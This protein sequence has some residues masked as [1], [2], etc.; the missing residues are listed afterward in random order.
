M[1]RRKGESGIRAE[2]GF[3]KLGDA[4]RVARLKMLASALEEDPSASF[5]EAVEDGAAL[6]GTY[7]LLSNEAG[8]AE[9]ILAGDYRQTV[10]RAVE[11]GVVLG[12]HDTTFFDFSVSAPR[13]GLG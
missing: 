9:D 1:A 4:R 10:E 2:F 3:A 6:E 7:R 12:V 8:N 13:G 5:P 11:Q